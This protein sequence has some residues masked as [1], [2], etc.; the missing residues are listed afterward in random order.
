MD[1]SNRKAAGKAVGKTEIRFGGKRVTALLIFLLCLLIGMGILAGCGSSEEGDAKYNYQEYPIQ[2]DGVDLHLDRVTLE[3]SQPEKDILLIHGA[4]Y[5]SHEFDVNYE[6]YSL[7][8]RLAREGYAVWRLDIAG[9]GRSEAVVNGLMPDTNHAA[10]DVNAAVKRIVKE[11]G[12][13]KIDMLGWSWGTMIAGRYTEDHP[14][15]VNRL[16]LYAPIMKGLGEATVDEPFHHNTWEHATEDFQHTT[17][18]SIDETIADPA[19][20]GMFA[21]NC[22]RYDGETSPNGWRKDAFVSR[23]EDL[24]HVDKITAPTLMIYGSMDPYMDYD[25]IDEAMRKLPKGSDQVELKGGSHILML[26]IP[27]H[28]EFQDKVVKFLEKGH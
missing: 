23:D 3:G 27:Y 6:D 20:V 18:G 14:D 10:Q 19:V 1:N 8:R 25:A 11:T 13:E 9:Y 24:I 4:T 22:W 16:V 2:R 28:Q 21:S 15:S 26:E 12:Q 5:S 17:E 7:V